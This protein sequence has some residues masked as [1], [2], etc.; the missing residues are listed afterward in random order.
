MIYSASTILLLCLSPTKFVVSVRRLWNSEASNLYFQLMAGI[1]SIR[2]VVSTI[3]CA[4]IQEILM[5]IQCI[6]PILLIVQIALGHSTKD[7]NTTVTK[8]QVKSTQPI[9]LDTI[10]SNSGGRWE[11]RTHDQCSTVIDA[12]EMRQID[13][14]IDTVRREDS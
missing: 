12:E 5:S 4:N 2:V 3:L 8:M 1:I 10:I 11:S 9:I 14:T 6:M 13:S 7:V